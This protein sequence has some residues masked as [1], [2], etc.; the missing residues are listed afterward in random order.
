[1]KSSEEKPKKYNVQINGGLKKK[2]NA[3]NN[4]T[5]KIQPLKLFRNQEKAHI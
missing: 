1:M 2:Q 4:I 3:Y 5:L